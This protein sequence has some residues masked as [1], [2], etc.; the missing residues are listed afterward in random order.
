MSRFWALFICVLGLLL[1]PSLAENDQEIEAEDVLDLDELFQD[2]VRVSNLK[3]F[4]GFLKGKLEEKDPD[5]VRMADYL[6][7]PDF[8][9]INDHMWGKTEFREV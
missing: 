1:T 2:F 7:S 6:K 9:A 5:A 4:L 3:D 8:K